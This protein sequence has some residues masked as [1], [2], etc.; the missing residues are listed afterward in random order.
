MVRLPGYQAAQDWLFR[1][2]TASRRIAEATG[3]EAG[4]VTAGA[5]AGLTLGAAAILTG[6]DLGRM[7]R[8]PNCDGFPHELIMAREQRNGYDHAVRAAGARLVEVGF[9]E[10]IAG[11]GVRRVEAWEYA[12]A[13]GPLTAGIVYVYGP[14]SRPALAEVVA[15]AREH[16]L[17]VLVDAAGELPPRANLREIVATGADLVA[18]SGGKAIR[19]PQATGLLCG[20]RE[21]VGAAALQMLDMDDHFDLWEPPDN[22]FDRTRLAGLPRHG[23][24]RGMKVSK[25]QIVALLTALRLFNEGAY[26]RELAVFRSYLER[27]AAALEW[28]GTPARG[29]LVVP[30]DGESLPVLEIGL[31]EAGLGR[32]ALDVCRRLRHGSPPVYVGHGRLDE[33]K[34][35]INPLHLNEARTTVLIR[36][37]VEELCP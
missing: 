19:G 31:D 11:A 18:F 32:S 9:H 5:A 1:A 26:D 14:H 15:V 10:P 4:L 17:S 25:E 36:R 22:L 16:G 35:V 6:Y 13:I 37:L 34:L 3:A 27:V 21:L 20:R 2:L 30:A 24:G 29:R 8:L 23:I 33:G 12:S 28:E 7:E